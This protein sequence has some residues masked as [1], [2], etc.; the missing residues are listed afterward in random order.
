LLEVFVQDD[1]L[2]PHL[3][4]VISLFCVVVA[5]VSPDE[6]EQDQTQVVPQVLV[7]LVADYLMVARELYLVLLD[8]LDEVTD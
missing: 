8:Q 4:F 6:V 1:A 5:L 7:L 2:E 3:V